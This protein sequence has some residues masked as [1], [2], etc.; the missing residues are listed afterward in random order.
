ME[1]LR[2]EMEREL[3]PQD[4]M[5]Q[6]RRYGNITEL[7]RRLLVSL[8]ERVMVYRDRRVELVYRWQ[9]EFQAQSE[10]INQAL[11]ERRAV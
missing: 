6:F 4:W 5:E 9:D 10:L 8:V 3:Q 2:E 11:S 7:D 1:T